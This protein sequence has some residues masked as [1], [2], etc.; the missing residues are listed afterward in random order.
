MANGDGSLNLQLKRV[1]LTGIIGGLIAVG[2]FTY[3]ELTVV[4]DQANEIMA[5]EKR[6]DQIEQHVDA[7]DKRLDRVHDYI[8]RHSGENTDDPPNKHGREGHDGRD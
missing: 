5:L 7:N 4:H 8:L 2:T 3:N 6:C 1:G